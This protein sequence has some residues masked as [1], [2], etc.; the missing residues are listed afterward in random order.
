MGV[1]AI[2]LIVL[3][4]FVFQAYTTPLTVLDKSSQFSYEHQAKFDYTTA[5][6]PSYLFGPEPVQQTHTPT[7]TPVP[8]NIAGFPRNIVDTITMSYA[9][10]TSTPQTWTVQISAVVENPGFWQKEVVLYPSTRQAGAFNINFSLVPANLDNV[11]AMIG[12]ET[13][14]ASEQPTITLK[15]AVTD[16]GTG[17]VFLQT[18]P[19]K[20]TADFIEFGPDLVQTQG[21]ARGAFNYSVKLRPNSLFSTP[22][23]NSFT[24]SENVTVAAVV[25]P[26]MRPSGE[27]VFIKLA[28]KMNVTFSYNLS[29]AKPV[30]NQSETLR[31][32]AVIENPKVWQKTINLIDKTTQTGNFKVSFPLDLEAVN[33]LINNIATETGTSAESYN[34]NIK[35]TVG[36]SGDTGLGKINELYAPVYAGT[37]KGTVLSWDTNLSQKEA[38]TLGDP[39]YLPNLTKI[40]GLSLSTARTLFL[41][42]VA[43]FL[44]LLVYLLFIPRLR[45]GQISTVDREVMMIK[46][47]AGERLAEVT[48]EPSIDGAVVELASS[49]GLLKTADEL[50]KPIIYHAQGEGNADP[51]FYIFDGSTCYRYKPE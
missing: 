8:A 35:A 41:I 18:L 15:A 30:N 10:R 14:L 43:L 40:M 19:L 51:C 22:V 11:T 34:V 36:V 50:G 23:I 31:V 42:F 1:C 16:V 49:D 21:D 13:N 39:V 46:A 7:P 27:P 37:I 20:L 32:D 28:Q 25:Q 9:Y 33:T 44:L 45:A 12:A 24:S 38:H 3:L 2:I 26:T 29:S 5:M 48:K 6:D 17:A 47:R 4:F